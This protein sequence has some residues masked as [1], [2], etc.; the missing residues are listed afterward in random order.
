[1]GGNG[2]RVFRKGTTIRDTWTKLRRGWDQE[3]E[4]TMAGVGGSDGGEM[5]TNST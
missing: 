2:G 3:R 1:M 4:V 5:Q